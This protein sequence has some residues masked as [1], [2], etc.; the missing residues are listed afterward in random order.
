MD[1]AKI[2]CDF[3]LHGIVKNLIIIFRRSFLIFFSLSFDHFSSFFLSGFW[4]SFFLGTPSCACFSYYISESNPWKTQIISW[5][6]VE[7][8]TSTRFKLIFSMVSSSNKPHHFHLKSI[9]HS[10]PR[11]IFMLHFGLEKTKSTYCNLLAKGWDEDL[12]QNLSHN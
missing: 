6:S 7:N 2:S 12:C 9:M 10:F 8:A 3:P 4:S 5:N 1:F 11:C